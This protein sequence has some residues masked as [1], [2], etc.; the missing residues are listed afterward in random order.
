MNPKFLPTTLDGQI[1]RVV[2]ESGEVAE[3]MG[4]V[5]Q[6]IGK[7]GRFGLTSA[8]PEGGPNNAA[9]LL[10]ELADLRHAISVVENGITD[11]ARIVRST[12][13]LVWTVARHGKLPPQR[14]EELPPPRIAE[15]RVNEAGTNH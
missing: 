2:E 9:L 5:L 3:V 1:D 7:T 14:H 10:S 8:H 13:E 4:R 15:E 11:R 6:I 12:S